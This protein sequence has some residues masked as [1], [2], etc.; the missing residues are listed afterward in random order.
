MIKYIIVYIVVF[1]SMMISRFVIGLNLTESTIMTVTTAVFYLVGYAEG[2]F[3]G[4]MEN[5]S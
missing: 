3:K 2:L 4:Q 5:K 1:S